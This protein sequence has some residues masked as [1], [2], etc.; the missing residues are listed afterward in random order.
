MARQKRE[1]PKSRLSLDLHDA[2]RARMEALRD[3][4]HADSMVE[5]VRNSLAVYSTLVDAIQEG[6]EV[7]I[8]AKDGSVCKL[9]ISEALPIEP[10]VSL[11]THRTIQS[12]DKAASSGS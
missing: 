6:G 1:L 10:V 4:T 8:H 7:K 9:L 12:V 3:T 2:V 5:V 11:D